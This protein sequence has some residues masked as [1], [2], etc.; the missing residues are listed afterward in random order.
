MRSSVGAPPPQSSRISSEICT[1]CRTAEGC[2]FR[3]ENCAPLATEAPPALRA[4]RTSGVR[5]EDPRAGARAKFAERAKPSRDFFERKSSA[6]NAL[7]A[8]A[9]APRGEAPR[10]SRTARAEFGSSKCIASCGDVGMSRHSRN[11]TTSSRK[12]RGKEHRHLEGGASSSLPGALPHERDGLAN[13]PPRRAASR[14]ALGA[15]GSN[16]GAAA[17]SRATHAS[18]TRAH[19]SAGNSAPKSVASKSR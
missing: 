11:L 1:V 10:G 12:R 13:D 17:R 14:F 5:R 2:R 4:L 3:I 6:C 19:A 7:R 8:P 9:F 15:Y 16:D 18:G